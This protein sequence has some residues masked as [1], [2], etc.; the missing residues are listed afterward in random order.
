MI[1]TSP[2]IHPYMTSG[3]QQSHLHSPAVDVVMY[4]NTLG[5]PP[6]P[7]AICRNVDCLCT[8]HTWPGQEIISPVTL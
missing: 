3:V 1:S 8:Q 4:D 7:I 6:N 2:S 5:K